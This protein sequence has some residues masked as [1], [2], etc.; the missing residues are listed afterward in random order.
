MPSAWLN[1]FMAS[2]DVPNGPQRQPTTQEIAVDIIRKSNRNRYKLDAVGGNLGGAGLTSA[3]AAKGKNAPGKKG[4]STIQKVMDVLSRPLYAGME[5]IKQDVKHG[6]LIDPWHAGPIGDKEGEFGSITKGLGKGLA[7][8]RKTTSADVYAEAGYSNEGKGAFA[9]NFG[10]DV[11]LDPINLI[12]FGA[13]YKGV[14]AARG[15]KE[16]LTAAERVEEALTPARSRVV[17]TDNPAYKP[18]ARRA[19][20]IDSPSRT[21][22]P[23]FDPATATP[24]NRGL[25]LTE[26]PLR[27]A[28]RETGP[29]K[30]TKGFLPGGANKV[31]ITRPIAAADESIDKL[32]SLWRNLI[33]DAPVALPKAVKPTKTKA[34]LAKV[35]KEE[36]PKTAPKVPEV[37]TGVKFK[38][39]QGKVAAIELARAVGKKLPKGNTAKEYE[40]ARKLIDSEGTV[41]LYH[42]SGKE[43]GQFSA[44]KLHDYLTTGKVDAPKSLKDVPDYATAIPEDIAKYEAHL[45]SEKGAPKNFYIKNIDENGNETLRSLATVRKEML[46]TI[47]KNGIPKVAKEAR[48]PVGTAPV[49]AAVDDLPDIA[50][51]VLADAEDIVKAATEG[52]PKAEEALHAAIESQHVRTTQVID[53]AGGKAIADTAVETVKGIEAGTWTRYPTFNPAKQVNNFERLEKAL[54]KEGKMPS[55]IKSP[56]S[57]HPK[58]ARIRHSLVM[59]HLEASEDALTAAGYPPM[60]FGANGFPLR[61]SDLIK[62]AG[63][64]HVV[65]AS[66][67]HLTDLFGSQAKFDKFLLENPEA[68]QLAE[69]S[70][71]NHSVQTA[72]LI[73]KGKGAALDSAKK[74]ELDPSLTT[75]EL[76]ET[77]H[78]APGVAGDVVKAESALPNPEA[79]RMAVANTR[80]F[81]SKATPPLAK[82]TEKHAKAFE[83]VIFTNKVT[84]DAVRG[85]IAQ[86]RVAMDIMGVTPAGIGREISLADDSLA[87]RGLLASLGKAFIPDF[88]QKDLRP[89]FVEKRSLFQQHTAYWTHALNATFRKYPKANR[90]QG[91]NA[92]TKGEAVADDISE[93][94][95]KELNKAMTSMLDH[96]GLR[97]ATSDIERSAITMD[98]LNKSLGIRNY[99]F[100][101]TDKVTDELGNELKVPWM[102]SW[103]YHDLKG[104]D[105]VEFIKQMRDAVDKTMMEKSMFDQIAT[106][107]GRPV[108]VGFKDIP[109]LKGVKFDDVRLPQIKRFVEVM[110]DLNK[111]RSKIRQNYEQI[112]RIWKTSVTIY[113]PSHHIRNFFGDTILAWL[114]GVN[115]PMVYKKAMQVLK[116]KRHLYSD[117]DTIDNLLSPEAVTKQ[118]ARDARMPIVSVAGKKLDAEQ[119]H[120]IMYNRGLLPHSRV[121][122]DIHGSAAADW[123]LPEPLKGKGKRLARGVSESR[124]HMSR[125]AHFIDVLAKSKGKTFD[126][127]IEEATRT[128]RKWHPDGLDLAG[129]EEKWM[130]NIF[131]FY[132]WM[133]KAVPLMLEGAVKKPAKIIAPNKALYNLQVSMGIDPESMSEP[134]PVDKE[135]PDWI[136]DMAYGPVLGGGSHIIGSNL[137]PVTSVG[138]Q[139]FNDP[140]RGIA[141]LLT[142]AAR[143]PGEYI[144]QSDWQTGQPMST[145]DKTE[146]IDKQIPGLSIANRLTGKN[147]G[148]GSIEAAITGDKSAITSHQVRDKTAGNTRGR[149]AFMNYL[150]A[151]GIINTQT[152]AN[153]KSAQYAKA[154]R[155]RAE[156]KARAER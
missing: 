121:V 47:K 54:V 31:K 125:T 70:K 16:A 154:D 64:I 74:A 140:R 120:S 42:L 97:A 144:S 55:N 138:E 3:S 25:A 155:I 99:K 82:V 52:S 139:L 100:R 6:G 8:K 101:F 116:A 44:S 102:D 105:P 92:I 15:G 86:E 66:R 146:Y 1:N 109:R 128:V 24:L 72:D 58:I 126:Q 145:M 106:I 36:L 11:L 78:E 127:A 77:L 98:D 152:P 69:I 62:A 14:K 151:A 110:D 26:N 137:N 48:T 85:A 75:K 73:E 94:A 12:P 115:N 65:M 57:N 51:F 147:L 61:L 83:K 122:E 87:S 9:R 39:D 35:V 143:I 108:G 59:K 46:T 81:I 38:L 13:I 93:A 68:A 149:D 17:K 119:V 56:T 130:R 49:A 33:G 148:A 27:K 37:P 136:R 91:W 21:F 113:S 111:P 84:E 23:P 103:K 150:F 90:I 96:S 117:I 135:F 142:P 88:A 133:R 18:Q 95:A 118:L 34:A 114:Q 28:V 153:L 132:S 129:F 10:T 29:S 5:A 4:P 79:V 107:W 43:G 141:G 19:P 22:A 131:P 41:T 30:I 76:A 71:A 112:L 80:E 7:G 2:L 60:T 63:G 156:N 50:D 45:F 104:Q 134:F 32:P 40:A 124:E 123:N 53:E 67:L 89:V 20:D